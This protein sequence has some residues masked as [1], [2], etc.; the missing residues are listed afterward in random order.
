MEKI[1]FDDGCKEF[2]INGDE[3]RILRFNPSDIGL[4]E[5]FHDSYEEMKK[6]LDKIEKDGGLTAAGDSVEQFGAFAESIKQIN[7][8]MRKQVDDIFYP[9]AAEIVFGRMNPLAISKGKTIY[10][11]FFEALEKVIKPYADAEA[12]KANNRVMKYKKSYDRMPSGSTGNK[13]K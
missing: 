11:N 3:K 4:I 12:K 7:S 5:R 10:E 9:G 8:V 1:V 13:R 2:A 6:E